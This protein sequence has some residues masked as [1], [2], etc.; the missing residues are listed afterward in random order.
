MTDEFDAIS[1]TAIEATPE[2][3][4]AVITDPAAAHEFMFGTELSTDWAPGGPIRW[5]GEW[6]GEPYEDHGTVLDVVPGERLVH[7]HYS[8]LSGQPD[9][10]EHHHTLTWTLERRDGGTV[11][12]LRQDGNATAEAMEHSK[13]MWDSLVAK[14]KEIAER[15]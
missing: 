13:R 3:V 12:T 11:L 15:G 10:P 9:L 5:R 6:H 1:T 4:W 2:R 14:V 8:P 7:T